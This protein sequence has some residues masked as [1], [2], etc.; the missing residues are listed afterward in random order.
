MKD[1]SVSFEFR[2]HEIGD[3]NSGPFDR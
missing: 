2:R 1:P 3:K